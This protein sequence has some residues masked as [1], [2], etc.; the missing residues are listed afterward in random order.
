MKL[1]AHFFTIVR[2]EDYSSV[3]YSY[4]YEGNILQYIHF[5]I[6]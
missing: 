3:L 6:A 1:G 2:T 5:Y 4:S